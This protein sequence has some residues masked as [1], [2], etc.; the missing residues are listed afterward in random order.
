M[1]LRR[2]F[3]VETRFALW[4]GLALALAAAAIRLLA[5]G[6]GA[7]VVAVVAVLYVCLNLGLRRLVRGLR[8]QV[9]ATQQIAL[10]DGLTNLPNRVLFH[11]R[12]EHAIR[13]G[14]T[15]RQQARGDAARPR[16]VQGDQRH[17]GPREG[18]RVPRRGGEPP[19]AVAAGERHD[20]APGRR[21]VRPDDPG[22]R[23]GR[24]A[25]GG[26][27]PAGPARAALRR[28]RPEP[29]RPRQHRDRPV[30]G[31]RRR[32]RDAP[33][34]G[35]RGDVRGQAGAPAGAL[36]PR[37]RP[38]LSRAPVA[39]RRA[40]AGDRARRAGRPLP[41]GR[42]CGVRPREG[43]RSA[44]ALAAS[45]AGSHLAGPVRRLRRADGA[46]GAADRG[47]AADR[48]APVRGVAQ[49]RPR[50]R[51]GGQRLGPRSRRPRLPGPRRVA[52]RR[53]RARVPRRWSSRSARTRSSPTRCAR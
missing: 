16:P 30:S 6:D 3:A 31:R 14:G 1:R 17:P 9:A 13:G 53:R 32:H 29:A 43:P 8:D 18:R 22:R 45:G 7:V 41:A 12:A 24:R 47:R 42:R 27:P 52:A 21:R 10:H 19:A 33:A 2:S 36:Q 40:Q 34:Q 25:A 46:D 44:G 51:G 49:G 5:G 4:T 26:E 37:A 48:A 23:H 50:R 11:D 39:D 28:R 20:R 38:L 35:R 15:G